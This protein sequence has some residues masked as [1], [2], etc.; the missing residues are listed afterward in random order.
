MGMK[1]AAVAI[2]CQDE[3][4]FSA[5]NMAGT[6]CPYEGKVGAEAAK[7]WV[8]NVD[9]RPDKKVYKKKLKKRAKQDKAKE[10]ADRKVKANVASNK[11]SSFYKTCKYERNE[12]NF[13]KSKSTCRKEYAK[14]STNA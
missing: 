2:M 6:P 12:D 9:D 5:M 1:V 3:R 7:M 11:W 4:V 13:K 8:A 10:K 14:L